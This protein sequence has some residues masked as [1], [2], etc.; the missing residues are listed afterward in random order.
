MK[1]ILYFIGLFLIFASPIIVYYTAKTVWLLQDD[2]YKT[3]IYGN[4]IYKALEKST[5][6]TRYK[7]LI[8]GDSTA[9]QFYN[10]KEEDPDS[11]YSLTCNQA[12][13]M[14]GQ[15]I[16]LNNYIEA[17]NKPDTIYLV[18]TPFS[19]WDNLD[20]VY[21]YH[22]FLKP[23]YTKEYKSFMTKTVLKQIK[24]IPKY[25]ACHIPFI[26]TTE[27]AP[28]IQQEHRDYS[29]ISPICKEYLFKIDSLCVQHSIHYEIVSTFVANHWKDS[30]HNFRKSEFANCCFQNKL[31]AFLNNITYL[32]DSCFVD[33]VHLHNPQLYIKKID[34]ILNIKHN[35]R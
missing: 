20:Q 4:E 33:E 10:C 30:I 24:K 25:W 18:F 26:Q 8:L 21:T 13:G 32:D 9:N 19:F 16:L 14:V 11:A 31:T 22:Y 28:N 35:I 3:T 2:K 27:W 5:K 23:F 34:S 1:R 17:G 15:F 12:I 29:F 7:K 6:K